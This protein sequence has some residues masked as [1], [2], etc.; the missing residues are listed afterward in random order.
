MQILT[1][2]KHIAEIDANP[3]TKRIASLP[4]HFGQPG[5]DPDG[6]LDGIDPR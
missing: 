4:L 2:D 6:A 3:K 1:F 5:L